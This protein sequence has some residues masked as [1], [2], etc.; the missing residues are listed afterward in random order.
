MAVVCVCVYVGIT[1]VTSCGES[2][3]CKLEYREE[4]RKYRLEC[5]FF[6]KILV[7]LVNNCVAEFIGRR[8]SMVSRVLW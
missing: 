8:S 5:T 6:E 2:Y 7:R 4:E 1:C 3:L